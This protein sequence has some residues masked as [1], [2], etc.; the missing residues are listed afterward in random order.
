[1]Y[2]HTSLKSIQVHTGMYWYVLDPIFKGN[3]NYNTFG[4]E[5]KFLLCADGQVHSSMYQYVLV[6]TIYVLVHTMTLIVHTSLYQYV[7]VCT[8]MYLLVFTFLHV[9]SDMCSCISGFP[10][11][12]L[13]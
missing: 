11:H 12:G 4:S 3:Q 5:D 10:Q 13:C 7:Q 8:S 2:I 9:T 6:C 1:M